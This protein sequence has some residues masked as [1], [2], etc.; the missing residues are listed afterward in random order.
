MEPTGGR[1]SLRSPTP[2]LL[3]LLNCRSTQVMVPPTGGRML[4]ASDGV[5]DAYEKMTRMNSMLR[6][7][8]LDSSPQRLIQVGGWVGG[9]VHAK[10]GWVGG[11]REGAGLVACCSGLCRVLGRGC[12]RPA[13]GVRAGRLY[14]A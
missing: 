8:T 13:K 4:V 12:R 10:Y 11:L 1:Q 14:R 3:P 6:S 5:W 7:W 2:L 9:W